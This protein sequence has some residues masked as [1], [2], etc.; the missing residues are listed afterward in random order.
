MHSM[1][2]RRSSGRR[3]ERAMIKVRRCAS[4]SRV[5]RCS[6]VVMASLHGTSV[7]LHDGGDLCT[8]GIASVAVKRYAMMDSLYCSVITRW[9]PPRQMIGSL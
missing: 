1:Q 2:L 3:F 6:V 5:S 7:L 8:S 9:L 4:A